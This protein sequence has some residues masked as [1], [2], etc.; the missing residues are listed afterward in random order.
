MNAE[1][2]STWKMERKN[3]YDSHDR[4]I[5]FSI[6]ILYIVERLLRS[7]AGVHFVK[8][9]VR[10]GTAPAFHHAE[11]QS[12]E[13]KKDFIHKMKLALKEPRETHINLKIIGE[14]LKYKSK[15]IW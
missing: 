10:C 15:E 12:T 9:L 3:R 6:L 8:Q 7:Y 14:T 5:K 2:R 1:H 4:L 13:S 11:A